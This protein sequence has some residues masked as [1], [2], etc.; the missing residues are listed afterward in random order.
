[1]SEPQSHQGGHAA[2]PLLALVIGGVLILTGAV[3]FF[4]SL[5]ASVES[6]SA[7]MERA[8]DVDSVAVRPE[9]LAPQPAP[10]ERASQ[11]P[12]S[13]PE[14]TPAETAVISEEQAQEQISGVPVSDP[15][16]ELVRDI[17]TELARLGYYTDNVDGSLG[18]R[19]IMAIQTYEIVSD[20]DITGQPSQ[21]LLADLRRETRRISED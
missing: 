10:S 5:T 18:R 3:W 1:M 8:E 16:V 15:K 4:S 14:A 2:A 11:Q 20:R 21:A 17:Q 13:S 12:L 7:K 9:P 6:W 19:T